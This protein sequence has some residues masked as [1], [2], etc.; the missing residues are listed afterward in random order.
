MTRN[1]VLAWLALLTA[2]AC[3]NVAFAQQRIERTIHINRAIEV[4][5]L[6]ELVLPAQITLRIFQPSPSSRLLIRVAGPIHI[7]GRVESD[8]HVCIN[9]PVEAVP[10]SSVPLLGNQAVV[11]NDL[12]HVIVYA[13]EPVSDAEFFD[14]ADASSSPNRNLCVAPQY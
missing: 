10:G 14:G 7:A 9:G 2:G 4:M 11:L 1:V 6:D 8:G 13:G 5:E 12:T 3:I